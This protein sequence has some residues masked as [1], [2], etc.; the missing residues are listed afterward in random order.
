MVITFILGVKRQER[1]IDQPLFFQCRVTIDLE[2]Y[3]RFPS[4]PAWRVMG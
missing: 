2:L 3:P 1:G 4:V